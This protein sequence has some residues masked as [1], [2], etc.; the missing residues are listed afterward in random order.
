MH[1]LNME[2]LRDLP[3]LLVLLDVV[4][5][6]DIRLFVTEP[7]EVERSEEVEEDGVGNHEALLFKA[8]PAAAHVILLDEVVASADLVVVEAAGDH[9]ILLGF[10]FDADDVDEINDFS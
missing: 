10:D 2:P 9:D 5:S 6:A 1:P 8:E 4:C 3:F 7:G